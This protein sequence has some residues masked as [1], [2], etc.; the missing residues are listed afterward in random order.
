MLLMSVWRFALVAALVSAGC[1][2]QADNSRGMS[3]GNLADSGGGGASGAGG[4]AGA[5][6]MAVEGGSGGAMAGA[7]GKGGTGGAGGMADAGTGGSPPAPMVDASADQATPPAMGGKALLVTG[8]IPLVGTDVQFEA[9]LKAR[10]LEVEIVQEKDATPMHAQGK[11][12][13]FL[14]YGM[15]SPAFKAEP[16]TDVPVPIIVT[17]QNL[18]PRLKLSSAHGFTGKMTKLTFVSDHE[19]AGGFPKGDVEVYSPSQE[20]FWGTPSPAAIRIAHLV[21]QPDKVSYFAYEKGAMMDG[22]VAPAKRVQ[23]FHAT[24]SPDPIDKNL[25]LNANGLKLLGAT[26]DWCLK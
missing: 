21:G 24:H 1:A 12:L 22:A 4:T 13:V 25:Y 16:F 20:F 7:G 8:T 18:L 14:S 10:G 26:I 11:R 19:L 2:S 23:F 15:S 6:G 5:G 3:P 9:A 17:E